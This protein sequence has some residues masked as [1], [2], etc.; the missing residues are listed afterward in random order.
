MYRNKHHQVAVFLAEHDAKQREYDTKVS[1]LSIILFSSIL[2]VFCHGI[3][4][5]KTNMTHTQ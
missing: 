2:I 5:L 1:G 3:V 4:L